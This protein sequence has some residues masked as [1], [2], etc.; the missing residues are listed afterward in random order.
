[1]YNLSR[2]CAPVATPQRARSA[3]VHPHR[4]VVC[5]FFGQKRVVPGNNFSRKQYEESVGSMLATVTTPAPPAT[6]SA[7]AV[8]PEQIA[9]EQQNGHSLHVVKPEKHIEETPAQAN[10]HAA[11]DSAEAV[12]AQQV[13]VEE[14]VAAEQEH[15]KA[16]EAT[17]EVQLP[18]AEPETVPE[19]VTAAELKTKAVTEPKAA[20]A[21]DQKEATVLAAAAAAEPAAPAEAKPQPAPAA[22]PKAAASPAGLEPSVKE[23]L[24]KSSTGSKAAGKVREQLEPT[25]EA[26]QQEGRVLKPTKARTEPKTPASKA[27]K[28]PQAATPRNLVFVTAEVGAT[29]VT[30]HCAESAMSALYQLTGTPICD[31]YQHSAVIGNFM[32]K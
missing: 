6:E 21:E 25:A 9:H 12:A 27:K 18:V 8:A 3:V 28:V 32:C 2:A 16:P 26:V 20:P 4:S 30:S 10:G 1:M 7:P 11:V 14:E 13:A 29:A 24:V 5:R 15:I 31:W 22:E 23:A 17:A 19:A